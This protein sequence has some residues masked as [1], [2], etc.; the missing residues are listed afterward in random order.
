V[1]EAGIIYFD[2]NQSVRNRMTAGRLI[3]MANGQNLKRESIRQR[4]K[5]PPVAVQN[6]VVINNI[7]LSRLSLE[8][9]REL[10]DLRNRLV[11][12]SA[13]PAD[14]VGPGQVAG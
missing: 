6:N 5:T 2:R 14:G 7:D 4:E 10:R 1:K 9:L 12:S 11:A 8:E 13:A 3:M